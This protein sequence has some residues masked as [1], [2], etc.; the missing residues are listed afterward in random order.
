MRLKG[1]E[2]EFFL[3]KKSDTNLE[4]P[5]NPKNFVPNEEQWAFIR[6]YY[7]GHEDP[8]Q[9]MCD[10]NKV[11]LEYAKNYLKPI[12]KQKKKKNKQNKPK[13]N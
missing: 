8:Y 6:M 3:M 7:N 13:V 5:E 4:D 12:P 9:L 11:G 2:S 1:K 10:L